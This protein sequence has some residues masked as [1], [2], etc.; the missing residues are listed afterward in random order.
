[1]TT[2][3]KMNPKKVKKAK[4]KI[5][6]VKRQQLFLERQIITAHCCIS[7]KRLVAAI[8]ILNSYYFPTRDP[9]CKRKNKTLK[10]K[11]E[12]S[13]FKRCTR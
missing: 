7:K 3:N 9:M 4:R 10:M 12:N 8:I 1:M 13:R 2:N 11:K 5:E 6:L